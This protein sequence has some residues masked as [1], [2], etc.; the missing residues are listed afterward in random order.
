[1]KFP[2]IDEHIKGGSEGTERS[3]GIFKKIVPFWAIHEKLNYINLPP[4]ANTFLNSKL[5]VFVM[6][7][8]PWVI[9]LALL[10]AAKL[11]EGKNYKEEIN[12]LLK[13][14]G[15]VKFYD[16]KSNTY[17]IELNNGSSFK[18]LEDLKG[19]IE[20]VVKNEVE[21]INDNFSYFIRLVEKKLELP[22]NIPFNPVLTKVLNGL[23]LSAGIFVNANQYENFIIDFMKTPHTLIAGATGWGKSVFLHSLILQIITNH[24]ESEF[25]LFDFKGGVE[26]KCYSNLNQTKSFTLDPDDAEYELSRVFNE[27]N[28]RLELINESD[29]KNWIDYNKK[30][31]NKIAPKFVIVEEFVILIDKSKTL[32]SILIKSLAISRITGVFFILTAQRFDAD[33]IDS[34]IKG[35]ID[36]RICFHVADSMNSKVILDTTGAEKLKNKGRALISIAGD[37][38]EIQTLNIT[39]ADI[40][41]VIKSH[42]NHK[43]SYSKLVSDINY[44]SIEK[45]E[46][47]SINNESTG[48]LI[49]G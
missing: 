9:G 2:K 8:L 46:N 12:D 42:L 21:I 31:T 19:K 45:S 7:W 5:E 16:S 38:S 36:N 48:G 39:D 40:D 23:K 20:N 11:V 33:V 25:E 37:I 29:T 49:W 32:K 27:I 1:M 22:T 6:W 26:L 3:G 4:T 24:P 41:S 43:K 47:E 28:Q 14:E 17:G 30:N 13:D 18:A 34:K 35:N 44:T 10:P 15:Y